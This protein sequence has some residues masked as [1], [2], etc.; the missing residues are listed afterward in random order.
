MGLSRAG[1]RAEGLNLLDIYL[2]IGIIGI[3]VNRFILFSD[4][5]FAKSER[6]T[7]RD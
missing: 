3:T 6:D 2:K 7:V 4:M 1:Q 5:Y